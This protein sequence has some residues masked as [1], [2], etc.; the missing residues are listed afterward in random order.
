M[1]DAL[2]AVACFAINVGLWAMRLPDVVQFVCAAALGAVF[3]AGFF[4]YLAYRERNP[5][6]R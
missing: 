2:A 6:D 1:R 5:P 4:G 3:R